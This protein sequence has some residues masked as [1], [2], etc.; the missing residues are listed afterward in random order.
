MAIEKYS[1]VQFF[2]YEGGTSCRVPMV[3]PAMMHCYK[4]MS[5]SVHRTHNFLPSFPG[6][7]I[8]RK[9]PQNVQCW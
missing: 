1:T 6:Y 8:R 7:R 4:F 5:I 2:K 9:I 3:M